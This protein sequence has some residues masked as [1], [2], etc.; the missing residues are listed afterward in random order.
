M[1]IYDIDNPLRD[2][3][4]EYFDNNRVSSSGSLSDMDIVNNNSQET[5]PFCDPTNPG[6]SSVTLPFCDITTLGQSSVTNDNTDERSSSDMNI[7]NHSNPDDDDDEQVFKTTSYDI[8][9]PEDHFAESFELM[10]GPREDLST[11]PDTRKYIE[12]YL[13]ETFLAPHKTMLDF[14]PPEEQVKIVKHINLSRKRKWNMFIEEEQLVDKQL[15]LFDHLRQHVKHCQTTITD[16]VEMSN[17]ITQLR[18]QSFRMERDPK[19]MNLKEREF[20]KELIETEFLYKECHNLVASQQVETVQ[21]K[22]EFDKNIQQLKTIKTNIETLNEEHRQKRICLEDPQLTVNMDHFEYYMFNAVYAEKR[23]ALK[24]TTRLNEE[25]EKFNCSICCS[26]ASTME[27]K[28]T[29]C[30]SRLVCSTCIP[31]LNSTCP[32]CRLPMDPKNIKTLNI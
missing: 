10:V 19:R 12:A 11:N 1:D 23:I 13:R 6:Q 20:D 17:K 29:P 4:D 5:L 18:K 24:A 32:F 25:I 3:G 26:S 28:I 31:K 16:I 8:L 22:A 30:C 9:S 27:R 7:D 21:L 15:T 14:E 2:I